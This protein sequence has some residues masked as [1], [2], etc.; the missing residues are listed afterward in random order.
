MTRHSCNNPGS[1]RTLGFH[2]DI[3]VQDVHTNN[4]KIY[5]PSKYK[6]KEPGP[7]NSSGSEHYVIKRQA[8]PVIV[9]PVPD[10]F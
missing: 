5:G 6:G 7:R 10:V 8:R 1:V 4:Q 3:S 2:S 9:D